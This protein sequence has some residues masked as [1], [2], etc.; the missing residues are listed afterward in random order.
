MVIERNVNTP[1]SPIVAER[2]FVESL[3]DDPP[4]RSAFREKRALTPVPK[5]KRLDVEDKRVRSK[6]GKRGGVKLSRKQKAAIVRE[7]ILHAAAEVVG[8]LGYQEASIA[9]IT[10]LAGIAQ[11][12]FY[13]YFETRQHLFDELLPHVGQD[14]IKFIGQ[15]VHGAKS[16]AEVEE[17]GIRAFFDFT[18]EHPGFYRLL[19]EAE[20]AAPEAHKKHFSQLI[21]HY[22]ASLKRSVDAGETGR[23]TD[24]EL[25]AV[26]WFMMAARSYIY[27]GYI[28][29]GSGRRRPPEAVIQTYLRL[30]RQ[31]VY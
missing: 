10:Q 17:K 19:N 29:Y 11:G 3:S 24:Q 8:E 9:R 7:R 2:S 12:T 16:Y 30:V 1:E 31:G 23:F 4:T 5:R 25:K 13:L 27:L 6:L 21:E 28:K 18:F 15:R 20:F 26:A 14:L 22:T